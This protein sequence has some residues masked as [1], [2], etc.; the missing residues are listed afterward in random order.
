MFEPVILNWV[1]MLSANPV[2]R[3]ANNNFSI[4]FFPIR[5]CDRQ[6]DSLSPNLFL[7]YIVYFASIHWGL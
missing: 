7:L 3:V 5:I 6:G 4:R 1:K 2:C